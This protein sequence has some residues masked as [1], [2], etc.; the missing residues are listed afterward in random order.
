MHTVSK[1]LDEQAVRTKAYELWCAK[2]SPDGTAEQDWFEALQLL[3]VAPARAKRAP[4]AVRPAAPSRIPAPRSAPV[5]E[6][7]NAP[8]VAAA[9]VARGKSSRAAKSR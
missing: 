1:S 4:S 5:I 2:G 6:A 9:G 3:R 8:R 7:K